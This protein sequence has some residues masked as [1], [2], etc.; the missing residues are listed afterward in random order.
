MMSSEKF[1]R[2]SSDTLRQMRSESDWERASAMTDEEIATA[3]ANDPELA[4]MD[5]AWLDNAAE[6][7]HQ[8]TANSVT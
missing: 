3:D 2:Y 1:V 7:A 8:H 5:D 4:G 6:A